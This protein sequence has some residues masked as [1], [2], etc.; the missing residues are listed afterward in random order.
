MMLREKGVVKW[1]NAAKGYGFVQRSTGED[2]FV[3]HSA[4]QM[5]G[6]RTLDNG[7]EVEFEVTQGPKG[8]QA[9]NVVPA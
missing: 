3:H 2:V 9:E 4:I 6:Y 5:N 7:G 1:F 8:L